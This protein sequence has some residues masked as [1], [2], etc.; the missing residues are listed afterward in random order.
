MSLSSVLRSIKRKVLIKYYGLKNV[1]PTF[2]ATFGLSNVSKDV[3]AGAYSYIGPGCLIYP[4]VSIGNYTMLANEVYVIGGDHNYRNPEIP[5]VFNGRD[6]LKPTV[7]GSDVWI[8]CRATIM[9]GVTIGNGAIVAAG[10][11]VT[12]DLDPYGIYAGVPAK[13]IRER[14][15]ADEIKMHMQMLECDPDKI[16]NDADSLLSSKL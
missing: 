7:I 6:Y 12:K 10:A 2:L 14:Y 16:K 8:G 11:V 15:N 3:V 4:K 13:K 1:H 9:T 5:A